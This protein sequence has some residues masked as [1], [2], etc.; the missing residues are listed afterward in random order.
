MDVADIAHKVQSVLVPCRR[1]DH[2]RDSPDF[3]GPLLV[4][5]AYAAVSLYGQLS[6]RRWRP[7]VAR[8]RLQVVSWILTIWVAGSLFI[9][10]L[11]QALGS[12]VS[13]SLVPSR[14]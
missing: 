4:V 8:L 2:I 10:V 1:R 14:C 11:A 3:W 13:F 9:A 6:V 5:L 7:S 12:D